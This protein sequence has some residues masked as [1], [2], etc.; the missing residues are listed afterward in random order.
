MKNFK[1]HTHTP[2]LPP[3]VLLPSSNFYLGG[4]GRKILSLRPVREKTVER[5]CSKTK[6]RKKN[7]TAKGIV[8][9]VEHLSKKSWDSIPALQKPN[10]NQKKKKSGMNSILFMNT[11]LFRSKGE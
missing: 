8:Q 3:P 4:G 5:S 11:L 2:Y 10:T 6:Q 9:V 7:K 1:T